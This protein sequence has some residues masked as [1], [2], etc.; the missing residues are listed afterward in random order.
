MPTESAVETQHELVQACMQDLRLVVKALE[1]YSRS[2]ERRFGLTGPQ[3]WALWE[4]GRSGPC[5]LKDLAARMKLDP[6]TVVGVVDRLVLKGL[7][8]RNPDPADRRRVSLVPTPRGEAL[9]IAAPHPAQGHLLAGLEALEREQVETLRGA[10][11]TLVQVMQ[12]E[13]LEA[14]FFFA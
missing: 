7:V 3:L 12:A 8:V 5:A 2:V 6:S 1:T 9:L 14:P 13:D 10:L 4:L 11:R